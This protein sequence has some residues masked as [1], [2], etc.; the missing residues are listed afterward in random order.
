M[1]RKSTSPEEQQQPQSH[2]HKP[3][4]RDLRSYYR[5]TKPSSGGS[6]SSA[7]TAKVSSA[8]A[9]V[10]PEHKKKERTEEE[11]RDRLSAIDFL[12]KF[13][14]QMDYGPC[15]GVSRM[16]RFHRAVRLRKEPDPKVLQ[17]LERFS[18]KSDGVTDDVEITQCLW[19]GEL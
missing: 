2:P 14:L 7:R 11:L 1:K 13:D 9:A 17:V 6:T 10:T 5:K 8:I 15:V 12:K 16:T 3:V 18:T 4:Q 19:H